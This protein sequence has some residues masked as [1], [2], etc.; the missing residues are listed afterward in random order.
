MNTHSRC[1]LALALFAISSVV[2]HAQ[3]TAPAAPTTMARPPDSAPSRAD[4]AREAVDRLRGYSVARRE[5]AV[6]QARQSAEQLDRQISQ[7]QTDVQTRWDSL[8]QDVRS[9][10][11]AAMAD[12]TTRRTQLAEW[13]GGMRHGSDQAWDE[14]RGGFVAS[15]HELSDAFRRAKARFDEARRQ[16]AATPTQEEERRREPR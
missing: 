6:A 4:E 9:S 12:V 10:M 5:E 14:V 15:Y 13:Y 8:G 2:S 3:T 7:L 11:G 16:P 1:A